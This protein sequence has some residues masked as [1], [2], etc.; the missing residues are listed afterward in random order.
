MLMNGGR[1][2]SAGQHKIISLDD[3]RERGLVRYFTGKAC[4]H[5][6]V[7]ERL[8][9]N[10]TCCA[11]HRRIQEGVYGR[12]GE[13]IRDRNKQYNQNNKSKKAASDKAYQEKNRPRLIEYYSARYERKKPEIVEKIK[14]YRAARPGFGNEIGKAY[15]LRKSKAMPLWVDR[16][17]IRAI[18]AEADRLSKETGICY[19]VDHIYPLKG[20]NSCGLHVPW[21]LQVI[22]KVE[23]CRKATKAPEEWRAAA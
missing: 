3:A 19:S 8:T 2:L 13:K 1:N 4:K 20:K 22:T 7:D 17:A 12:Y 21:N 23:N 6:H 14:A 16:K 9:S 18:Y 11:C 5:G 10:K 15:I